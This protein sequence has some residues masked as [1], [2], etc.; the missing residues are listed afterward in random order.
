[1]TANE[2]IKILLT[3]YEC[4]ESDACDFDCDNCQRSG[5]KEMILDALSM[6]VDAL[7][8][9]NTLCDLYVLDK[10]T[11]SIHR[12]GEDAHDCLEVWESGVVYMNLQNGDGGNVKDSATGYVLLR[13]ECGSL[14]N[15]EGQPIDERF[16]CTVRK[17]LS[18]KEYESRAN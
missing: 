7:K 2:A 5:D 3:Q 6:A 18:E 12:V 9:R 16:A 10:Q 14:I 15:R 13:S 17:Y 1:M 4:V 11:F 8:G